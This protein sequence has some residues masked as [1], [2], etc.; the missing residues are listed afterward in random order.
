M[1]I[2]V[3][4]RPGHDTRYAINCDKI[5]TEIGWK[6]QIDFDKGLFETVKWYLNNKEWI[7]NIKNGY[8]KDWVEKQYGGVI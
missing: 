6:Q 7:N 4:D 8:Y 1:I 3:K 2:F 5:K